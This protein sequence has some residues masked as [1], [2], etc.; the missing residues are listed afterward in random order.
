MAA[1]APKAVITPLTITMVP[2]AI[3]AEVTGIIV[4]LRM[5]NVPFRPGLFMI[6]DCPKRLPATKAQ[7]RTM[8]R[9]LILVLRL[10]RGVF[11]L[12]RFLVR[13]FLQS[14]RFLLR[15]VFAQLKVALAIEDDLAV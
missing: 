11:L 6:T 12:L 4:A 5:A 8:V 14:I 15:Q 9:L 2:L 3:G 10:L 13:L 1:P 7:V